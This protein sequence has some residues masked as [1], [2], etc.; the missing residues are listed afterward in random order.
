MIKKSLAVIFSVLLVL[1]TTGIISFA[2]PLDIAT[3]ENTS[4]FFE[5]T[6]E[7]I[8]STLPPEDFGES[9][10]STSFTSPEESTLGEG[11]EN[12]SAADSDVTA[13]IVETTESD[14]TVEEQSSED[15]AAEGSEKNDVLK[16]ALYVI[17]ALIVVFIALIMV[18]IVLLI[19][20]KK[21]KDSIGKNTEAAGKSE[22]K[23]KRT[24][25]ASKAA[26]VSTGEK[27]GVSQKNTSSSIKVDIPAGTAEPILH[28]IALETSNY[29]VEDTEK[30]VS[31]TSVVVQ[32]NEYADFDEVHSQVT[33][34]FEGTMSASDFREDVKAL[35]LAN[36]YEMSINSSIPAVFAKDE[37]SDSSMFVLINDKYLYINFNIFNKE[38]FKL[39]SDLKGIEFIFD[40]NMDSTGV[41]YGSDI[42]SIM[43]TRIICENGVYTIKEK[44]KIVVK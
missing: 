31:K 19:K 38:N 25:L 8:A 44:G 43:P 39:Y 22:G 3:T 16:L 2:S 10:E 30:D 20:L 42:E 29:V 7:D 40:I 13:D 37:L 9:D 41:P 36:M 23:K 6:S 24:V 34:I 27:T 11:E 32:Q 28:T 5:N 1:F 14:L 33:K 15:V 26:E 17:I 21:K 35:V 18:L 12:S 4:N